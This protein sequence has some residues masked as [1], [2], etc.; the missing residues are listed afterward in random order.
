MYHQ[1]KICKFH[2]QLNAICLILH[3]ASSSIPSKQLL[4]KF[5]MLTMVIEFA[6]TTGQTLCQQILIPQ[7]NNNTPRTKASN[8]CVIS[9]TS[10]PALNWVIT[11]LYHH[12]S[13]IV[14]LAKLLY[15]YLCNSLVHKPL[16]SPITSSSKPTNKHQLPTIYFLRRFFSSTPITAA[17]MSA[18]KTKAQ[19]IIDENPVGLFLFHFPTL[20]SHMLMKFCE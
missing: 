15:K 3:F 17:N 14:S 16:P 5:Q 20:K 7:T 4:I 10:S 1:N 13:L 12:H 11:E 2:K 19:N 6:N 8:P 18:A 9:R